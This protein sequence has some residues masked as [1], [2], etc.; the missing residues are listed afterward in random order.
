MAIL[1]TAVP[2]LMIVKYGL[3]STEV[4]NCIASCCQ[5]PGIALLIQFWNAEISV[6]PE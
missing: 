5:Y 1:F 2:L 3:I 4:P 6:K